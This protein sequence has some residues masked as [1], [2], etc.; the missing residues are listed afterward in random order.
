MVNSQHIKFVFPLLDICIQIYEILVFPSIFMLNQVLSDSVSSL[1]TT[2]DFIKRFVYENVQ[3]S[4]LLCRLFRN[5]L[6]LFL[7]FVVVLLCHD[8]ELDGLRRMARAIAGSNKIVTHR[9]EI[10]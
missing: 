8:D 10:Y 4:F 2:I 5:F 1:N 6:E 9:R 3:P 7:P